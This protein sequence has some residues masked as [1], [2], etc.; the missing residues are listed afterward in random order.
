MVLESSD[1][2]MSIIL[3]ML[4]KFSQVITFRNT[5]EKGSTEHVSV[6]MFIVVIYVSTEICSLDNCKEYE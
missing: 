5:P 1:M 6:I 2:A 3:S 4:F